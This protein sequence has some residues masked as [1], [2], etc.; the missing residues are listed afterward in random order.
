M[1]AWPQLLAAY[2]AA[3]EA[4]DAYNAK[5]FAPYL[6]HL[7]V[8][9][10]RNAA[11]DAIPVEHEEEADRLIKARYDAEDPLMD[12]PSPDLRAFAI[13]YLIA[14]GGGRDTDCWDDMLEEEAKRF[15]APPANSAW[16]TAHAAF[17]SAQSA[18]EALP[19]PRA[20]NNPEM[21][22]MHAAED[23]LIFIPAPDLAA[24]A[25]KM[26]LPTLAECLPTEEMFEAI[27]ADIGR[28]AC[29]DDVK[30]PH[31]AWL[32]ERDAVLGYCN[33]DEPGAGLPDEQG[34]AL[35]AAF[36]TI[37]SRILET[38]ASTPMG[39]AVKLLVLGQLTGQGHA[40]SV[41]EAWPVVEEAA[42]LLGLR[43]LSRMGFSSPVE[44][45]AREDAAAARSGNE[46]ME[47]A[48]G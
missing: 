18:Y 19:K 4:E 29:T 15:L 41:E 48:H 44:Q 3:K 13:K 47:D 40:V 31:R 27:R 33:S 37:E 1:S 8:G 46:A 9:P 38:P 26:A 20:D 21:L 17:F 42:A 36:T 32:D 25:D 43:L 34:D 6:D 35:V 7:P 22:A 30:D 28:L 16:S 23:R 10:E 39:A 24:L 12:C 11:V 5:Y 2:R 45:A 14:H